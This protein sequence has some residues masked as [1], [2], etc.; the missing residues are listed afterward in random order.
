MR[1]ML[2]QTNAALQC[3]FCLQDAKNV[4]QQQVAA[5]HAEVQQLG[6]HAEQLQQEGRRMLKQRMTT[7]NRCQMLQV[8]QTACTA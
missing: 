2:C 6:R 1:R 8:R 5:L 3:L 7:Q 4:L